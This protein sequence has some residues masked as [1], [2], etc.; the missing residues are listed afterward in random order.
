MQ[1]N[2]SRIKELMAQVGMPDSLS[3]F[4]AFKQLEM[5]TAVAVRKEVGDERNLYHKA[6]CSVSLIEQNTSSTAVEKVQSMAKVARMAV[7]AIPKAEQNE[8]VG[9]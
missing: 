5:E 3:L 8:A 4:Q 6:L 9:A 2:E 7:H 1:S